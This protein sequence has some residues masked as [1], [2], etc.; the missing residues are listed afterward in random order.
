MF[1]TTFRRDPSAW[2]QAC[3]LLAAGALQVTSNDLS[4]ARKAVRM[5]HSLTRR[6]RNSILGMVSLV[7][8]VSMVLVAWGSQLTHTIPSVH[9]P[10]VPRLL[11]DAF[12]SLRQACNRVSQVERSDTMAH[13]ALDTAK[14]EYKRTVTLCRTEEATKQRTRYLERLKSDP[15]RSDRLIGPLLCAKDEGLP[16]IMVDE[17]GQ[18]LQGEEVVEGA[19]KY[20]SA[21]DE[22]PLDS[23]VI[24]R[25][26]QEAAFLQVRR[27]VGCEV[28]A[29]ILQGP[30]LITDAH[31]QSAFKGINFSAC[32]RGLPY[33][34]FAPELL[35]SRRFHIQCQGLAIDLGD[36][37]DDWVLQELYHK[38]KPN[39]SRMHFSGY[40]L[41]G[42]SSPEGRLQQELWLVLVHED[43][44]ASPWRH[45]G[46]N[47]DARKDCVA[48][49]LANTLTVGIREELCLPVGSVWGDRKEAFDTSWRIPTLLCMRDAMKLSG[50]MFSIA[51]RS[52][53]RTRVQV[54]R[55]N[56]CSTLVRPA[57]GFVEGRKMSPLEFCLGH[58]ALEKRFA[59]YLVGLGLNPPLEAVVAFRSFSDGTSDRP[60]DLPTAD[61]LYTLVR[62]GTWTWETV[63][64]S[65]PDDTT[66]LLLLD[67]ASTIRRDPR[68]FV[69]D[70]Y[71]P[72]GSHG[73]SVK[74]LKIMA[75]EARTNQY[76]Y[77]D[78]K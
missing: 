10:H 40:R 30:V 76:A 43:E 58:A 52:L 33:A 69:D 39:K 73:H 64:E 42:L 75:G 78:E 59:K 56:S 61:D 3:K 36:V 5:W 45:V 68:S 4:A 71:C 6:Q 18:M 77:R 2:K 19:A 1:Y 41:L 29:Q 17:D 47:Q 62:S 74:A 55:Y 15:Q 38:H 57:V 72:V 51:E 22:P 28:D 32:C 70:T 65:A 23:D 60:Y 11:R 67:L 16:G 20:I 31:I 66:R 7:W 21:R 14:L 24:W 37:A 27:V 13:A 8:K 50:R 46:R 12:K 9:R 44:A 25:Q 48:V 26:Q 54:V 35:D 34:A 49:S 53:A 63:M